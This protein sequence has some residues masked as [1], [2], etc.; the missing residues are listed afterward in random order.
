[1]YEVTYDNPVYQPGDEIHFHES[2]V[3]LINGKKVEME[4]V[5]DDVKSNDNVKVSGRKGGDK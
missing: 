5:P 1:M 3:V 2:G 4:S